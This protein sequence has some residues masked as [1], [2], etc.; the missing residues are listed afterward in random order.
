MSVILHFVCCSISPG[1]RSAG[2]FLQGAYVS[3]VPSPGPVC[4][5]KVLGYSRVPVAA[6]P[7]TIPSG[8]MVTVTM[9]S[10]TGMGYLTYSGTF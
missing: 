8:L 3:S 6:P 10:I 4:F 2:S 9:A 1:D 5:A 7:L